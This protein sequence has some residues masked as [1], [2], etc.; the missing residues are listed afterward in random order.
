MEPPGIATASEPQSAGR[1]MIG[2]IPVRNLWLLML[3]ASEFIRIDGQAWIRLD[4][5]PEDLPNLVA[6][7][8]C[9]IVEKRLRRNLSSGYRNHEDVLTR[10]RGRIDVLRTERR[11]LLERGRI[12][13]RFEQ[14]TLDTPRNRLVRLALETLARIASRNDLQHRCRRLATDF[15][16]LGVGP[17]KPT[18]VELS[19]DRFGRNDAD[20]RA[21]VALS[22]LANDLAL[23][24]EDAGANLLFAPDRQEMWVRRLYEKALAGFYQVTL[25][26]RGWDVRTGTHLRWPVDLGTKRISEILPGMRADIVL[27]R[28]ADKRHVVI[29]T[30]FNAIVTRGWYREE[31]LLRSGY[32]YQIYAYLRSQEGDT[33]A[34]RAEGLLLHPAIDGKVVDEAVRMQGHVIR[35]STVDL[36]ATAAEIRDRLMYVVEKPLLPID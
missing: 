13:C 23:P 12:A 20:D 2:R 10:V 14:L 34:D 22:A 11:R 1:R 3:Y 31:E 6:E 9:R 30:K 19:A 36:C 33:L 27:T 18:A 16:A 8:L 17:S 7:L 5:D 21:M 25:R 28:G 24:T 35:F 32:L 29:D 26:H 4:E 15:A